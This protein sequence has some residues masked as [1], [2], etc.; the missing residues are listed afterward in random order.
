MSD[1]KDEIQEVTSA[2]SFIS[3]PCGKKHKTT[4]SVVMAPLNSVLPVAVPGTTG[5]L[6]KST[7]SAPC[8]PVNDHKKSKLKAFR[9]LFPRPSSPTRKKR[10]G[11]SEDSPSDHSNRPNSLPVAS[12]WIRK[13]RAKSVDA[14]LNGATTSGATPSP[15]GSLE[16]L[17]FHSSSNSSLGIEPEAT[18]VATLPGQ[19][20]E[21][22]SHECELHIPTIMVSHTGDDC[23]HNDNGDLIRKMSQSSHCSTMHSGTSGVGSLLSTGD[24]CDPT[25]DLETPLTPMSPLSAISSD[26]GSTEELR[27]DLGALS[28]TDYIDKDCLTSPSSDQETLG[29]TTPPPLRESPPPDAGSGTESS[30][31][32]KVGKKKRDR[33]SRVSQPM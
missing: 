23:E 33:P 12:G 13:K 3:V 15:M 16:V 24:E 26:R 11:T 31:G 5:A 32:T 27:G 1:K 9:K 18:P 14:G 28:D 19:K 7:M 6:A 25:S 8:S 30:E 10:N 20:L 22:N 21:R 2:Q 4:N 29:V 17:G